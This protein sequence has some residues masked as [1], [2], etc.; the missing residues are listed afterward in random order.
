MSIADR[1][2][3]LRKS[4][5]MSQEQ[6]AEAM[7]VSR[8]A[9]SKWESEQASPDPEKIIAMSEIFGVTTD[10]LLKGIEPEKEA[11]KTTEGKTED[12]HMTVGDV[13]DQKILTEQNKEKSK[14]LLKYVLIAL[15]VFLAIDIISF[16]IYVIINGGL[17]G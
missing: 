3:T 8:Q 17:P 13:L 14:K 7:G 12:A 1:I 6:L 10:Y 16:I 2:L 9:V 11:E 4:K 5:G 15:G